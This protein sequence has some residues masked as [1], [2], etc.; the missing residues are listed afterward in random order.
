ME[1]TTEK[2]QQHKSIEKLT[3]L[4]N[5]LFILGRYLIV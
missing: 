4:T 2:S 5:V 1:Q 3:Q